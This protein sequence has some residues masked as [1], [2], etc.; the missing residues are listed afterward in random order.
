MTMQPRVKRARLPRKPSRNAEDSVIS[1]LMYVSAS[2][3]YGSRTSKLISR[4]RHQLCVRINS[5]RRCLELLIMI[6]E[7]Y[8]SE[9]QFDFTEAKL[10][11][12]RAIRLCVMMIVYWVRG[13]RVHDACGSWACAHS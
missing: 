11:V 13:A 9:I 3:R 8:G 10:F 7:K 5:I 12:T 1:K 6:E 4:W 2:L